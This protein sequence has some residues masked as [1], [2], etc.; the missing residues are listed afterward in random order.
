MPREKEIDYQQYL[1][2]REW[3]AKR[4]EVIELA[5]GICKRCASRPIENVHHITYANIGQ[6]S[7]SDL[8]GVCRP[9]HEYLAAERNDDPALEII[10]R[11]IE[12]DG[13]FPAKV[14]P[15]MTKDYPYPPFISGEA[16]YGEPEC[17]RRLW[18]YLFPESE[19]GGY[20][21]GYPR[22]LVA[23][24]VMGVFSWL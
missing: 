12:K 22:M 24:A 9:C 6:E 18:M 5:D 1:A 19:H 4:K 15:G 14:W 20:F 13:L 21:R 17:R 7:L 3:R 2:S 11:I 8:L 16:E 10:H 23:P